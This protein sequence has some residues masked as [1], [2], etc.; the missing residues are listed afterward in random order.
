MKANKQ[1][2]FVLIAD[3]NADFWNVPQTDSYNDACA[4]GNEFGRAFVEHC[5]TRT[6]PPGALL[7]QII[8]G[9]QK[10]ERGTPM[11]GYQVGFL[12]SI[13]GALMGI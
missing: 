6:V 8:N 13:E 2:P 9:M 11:F 7:V 10:H 12:A 1:L 3:D 5:Q 4:A